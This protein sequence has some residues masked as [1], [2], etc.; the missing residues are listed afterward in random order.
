[1]SAEEIERWAYD[2]LKKMP[3]GWAKKWRKR[4]KNAKY[5]LKLA[6]WMRKHGN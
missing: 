2:E 6:K 3:S 1:M 4:K 5:A